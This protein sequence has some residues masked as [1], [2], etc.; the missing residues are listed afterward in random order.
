MSRRK[1]KSIY[2][3]DAP[4]PRHQLVLVPT[5]LEDLIP[6]DHPVRVIDEILDSLNW[7]EY[8]SAYNGLRGKPPIPPSVMSKVLLFAL[9]RRIRSSRQIEYELK[10]SIDFMWLT[11]GRQIDHTTISEFRR[12][13]SKALRGIFQQMIKVAIDLG[14]ANLSELCID[15]TRVLADASR[16]KT[17]TTDRLARALEQLDAQIA[18]AIENLEVA[19][20]LDEDLLGTDISADRLP[21]AVANLKQRREQLAKLK[22]TTQEM[23]AVR[24]KN[25][26]KGS[27]QLPKTDPE[28]RILPNK[29]GGY[30]ANFTPMATTETLSG[31][32]V[33]CE[34]VIGNVEHDQFST[35]VDTVQADF[36]VKVSRVLADTA[37]TA[38]ENLSAA[39]A[40]DVELIGPLAEPKSENNPAFRSDLTQPVAD[41]DI[42][43]LPVNPQTKRFDKSAFVYDAAS[44]SYY[45][46]AGKSLPHRTTENKCHANGK[47]VQRQVYTC[48]QCTGCPLADRCRKNPQSSRG[49]EVMHDQHEGARRRHRERMKSPEAQA[50]YSRRQH[51]GETPFAVIKT[52]FDMRRFLLRGVEGVGQEWRW[53]STAFNLRKLM[54]FTLRGQSRQL[55]LQD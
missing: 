40:K 11:S 4:M 13:H 54:S 30:A 15:G 33:N 21:Q 38:G 8:E 32:I 17:W 36:H 49:R 2:W 35:I 53:A 29:E 50:A 39:E 28:S 26:S 37:Y 31:F 51:F 55:Q 16:Y 27:A 12:K 34:V 48:N 5:A 47:P 42:D 6:E 18:E 1:R 44:D 9:I 20:T 19:D 45:C 3:Q 43:R 24:E 14:I 22:Q 25:G 10:H 23:D 7:T 46:P 52:S 41:E